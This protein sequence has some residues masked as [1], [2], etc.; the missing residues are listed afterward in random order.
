MKHE[1]EK[2]SEIHV[3]MDGPEATPY[4]GG[5]FRLKLVLNHDFPQV[6]TRSTH[7]MPRRPALLG[8]G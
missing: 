3:E 6:L 1:D 7:E 5:V 4:R 2:I 8:A